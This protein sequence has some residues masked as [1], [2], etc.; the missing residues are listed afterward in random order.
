VGV[1]GKA[2]RLPDARGAWR[3]ASRFSTRAKASSTRSRFRMI[4]RAVKAIPFRRRDP[5]RRAGRAQ[6]GGETKLQHAPGARQA[7][8]ACEAK[9]AAIES[10]AT[11]YV[12]DLLAFA[13]YDLR[14][15]PLV[16]RKAI[17]QKVLPQTGPLRYSE[18][19][20]KN[21]RGAVRAGREVGPRRHHGEEGGQPVSQRPVRR[22]AEDSRRQDRRLHRGRFHQAQRCAR[23]LRVT[24]MSARTK[25]ANSS[26]AVERVRDSAGTSW[27]RFSTTLQGL[28]RKT[29]PCEPPDHGALPKGPDTSSGSSRRSYAMCVT[30]RSRRTGCSG[31]PCSCAFGMIRSRRMYNAGKREGGRGKGK[32]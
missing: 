7:G 31:N 8:C 9:R 6:R 23:R 12:F 26:I 22:L 2:R 28:V 15:L 11:L 14:K 16:A 19:F 5:G 30:K 29:P 25:T 20:E 17:L 4:A 10:P 24:A 13:G 18:H 3:T 27:T 32:P 21:G 1:R